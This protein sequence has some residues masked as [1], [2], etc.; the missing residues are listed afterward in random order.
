MNDPQSNE[1]ELLQAQWEQAVRDNAK[2]YEAL[3]RQGVQIDTASVILM[4]WLEHVL[5]AVAGEEGVLRARLETQQRIAFALDNAAAQV[6]RAKLL[7]PMPG[8][9]SRGH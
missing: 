9:N 6:S 2:R 7:A 1:L 3:S 4:T 5:R 8:S